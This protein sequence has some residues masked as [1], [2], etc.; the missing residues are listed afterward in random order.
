M[1]VVTPHSV[2]LAKYRQACINA[3]VLIGTE[4][5]TVLNN[6]DPIYQLL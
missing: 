3:I 2:R 1:R 5:L 4:Y 6:V